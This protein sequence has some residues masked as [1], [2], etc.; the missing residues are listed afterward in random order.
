MG[1]ST[2]EGRQRANHSGRETGSTELERLLLGLVDAGPGMLRVQA[3]P[4]AKTDTVTL[5]AAELLTRLIVGTPTAAANY[6]L[7]LGADLEA[8]LKAAFPDLAVGDSFDFSII[9]VATNA[10]FDITVVTNTGWTLVGGLVVESNEATATR[11]PSGTF[12]AR[13]TAAGTFTLYRL[14]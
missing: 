12:R 2:S 5:T 13:R 6:T 14:S 3:A 9:N 11:G 4:A 8:A 7:P 10:S 1:L